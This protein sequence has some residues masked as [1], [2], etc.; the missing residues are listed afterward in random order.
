MAAVGTGAINKIR[1]AQPPACPRSALAKFSSPN[2]AHGGSAARNGRKE[3]SH[4]R[5]RDTTPRMLTRYPLLA[6]V[7]LQQETMCRTPAVC[8]ST[9]VAP[10]GR[11]VCGERPPPFLVWL[12]RRPSVAQVKRYASQ[13]LAQPAVASATAI[14]PHARATR[15]HS[16]VVGK[17]T[18]VRRAESRILLGRANCQLLAE[19]PEARVDA[20]LAHAGAYFF[21]PAGAAGGAASIPSP[22]V[23]SC[24]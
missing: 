15:N 11:S 24:S 7:S 16:I 5:A 2:Q 23:Y 6:P 1:T 21:L 3:S 14:C 8:T 13:Q 17:P 12:P 10:A 18:Y 19:T 4:H 22:G 9:P 20:V